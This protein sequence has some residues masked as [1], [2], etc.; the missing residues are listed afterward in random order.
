M[1]SLYVCKTCRAM[2]LCIQQ[3]QTT[4][5]TNLA[6][7]KS[8][9][10]YSELVLHGI[11]TQSCSAVIYQIQCNSSAWAL[12]GQFIMKIKHYLSFLIFIGKHLISY[13]PVLQLSQV[14]LAGGL[15]E[16]M[17]HWDGGVMS[18]R[19]FATFASIMCICVSHQTYDWFPWWAAQ[20][21]PFQKVH[22][23]GLEIVSWL[24]VAKDWGGTSP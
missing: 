6:K 4:T 10:W 12:E 3:V 5:N 11:T 16:A 19:L 8:G 15:S 1:H 22:L 21:T 2:M 7:S 14:L 9:G 20:Y 23:V 13:L 17:W 24:G 18:H